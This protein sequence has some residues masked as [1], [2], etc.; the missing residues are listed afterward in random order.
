VIG[1]SIRPRRGSPLRW[2]RAQGCLAGIGPKEVRPGWPGAREKGD[3]ELPNRVQGLSSFAP[4]RLDVPVGQATG[5]HK[6][7]RA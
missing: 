2:T 3:Q 7:G 4:G 6:P 1:N 5:V